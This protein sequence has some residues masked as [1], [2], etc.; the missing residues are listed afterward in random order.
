MMTKNFSHAQT[1]SYDARVLDIMAWLAVALAMPGGNTLH[2]SRDTGTA[3]NFSITL[4]IDPRLPAAVARE[5]AREA[6]AIWAPY[7]IALST[8][9][10]APFRDGGLTASDVLSIRIVDGEP[11]PGGRST[12]LASIRFLPSGRPDNV[13]LLHLDAIVRLSQDDVEVGGAAHRLP[14]MQVQMLSRVIG[15]LIAHEIGHFVL[16]SPAHA[17]RGLMR[18]N[19][20]IG[21]LA[22]TDRSRFALAPE[23]VVRLRAQVTAEADR[24]AAATPSTN[25]SAAAP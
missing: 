24:I 8:I 5:A 22:G 15:R 18:P 19:H 10:V 7:G 3:T 2:G 12:P 13:I 20:L 9:D 4:A 16:R 25:P 6:A 1:S 21:D 11:P 14:V 23:N 17:T